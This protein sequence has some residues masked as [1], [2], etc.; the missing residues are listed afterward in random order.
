MDADTYEHLR[1]LA[2]RYLD[3]LGGTVQPTELVHEAWAKL[4]N[5]DDFASR[6]HF[7]AVAARAM[8]QILTDR[9]RRRFA[10][11]RGGGRKPI[12]V[13]GLEGEDRDLV[14]VLAL[15]EAL[16]KLTEL[17]DEHASIVELRFFGG[18]TTSE[19]AATLDRST[20]YVEKQWRVV[21][22]W[23]AIELA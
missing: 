19:I 8:R 23:L 7:F 1:A 16:N 11:K 9:A 18:L 22:A 3:E 15:D 4:R 2:N 12:T 20:S 21:R 13:A 17:N 10:Q 6:E 5:K 14:D